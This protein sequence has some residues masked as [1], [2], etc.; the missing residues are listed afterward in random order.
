MDFC[1]QNE[2][3]FWRKISTNFFV[4]PPNKKQNVIIALGNIHTI[5]RKVS[6][7]VCSSTFALIVFPL[8]ST[9]EA[10]IFFWKTSNKIGDFFDFWRP[11]NKKLWNFW[12][13]ILHTS[14]V[15]VIYLQMAKHHVPNTSLLKVMISKIFSYSWIFAPKISDGRGLFFLISPPNPQKIVINALENVY[16]IVRH[17]YRR[18][19]TLPHPPECIP[20]SPQHVRHKKFLVK[21]AIFF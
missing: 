15:L 9:C 7:Q 16:T 19:L 10:P 8:P 5:I 6:R 3:V 2:H 12:K 21:I 17:I 14:K 1:S 20:P 18:F 11:Q 13:M 4:S